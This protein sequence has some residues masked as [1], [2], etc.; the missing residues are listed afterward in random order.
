[1]NDLDLYED[2]AIAELLS[3][4]LLETI[5]SYCNLRDLLTCSLVCK[6]WYK[7]LSDED[8]D[9]WRLHCVKRL[10]EEVTK[11]DL[12]STVNT[13]KSKLRAFCHAWNPHDCSRNVYV[14]PNG[15]TLHR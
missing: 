9:V 2:Y 15:F 4:P 1:M 10:P 13:Y 7:V 8:N 6:N 14:K 3:D 5:F 11:S 12:L